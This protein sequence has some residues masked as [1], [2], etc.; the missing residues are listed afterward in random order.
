MCCNEGSR[1]PCPCSSINATWNVYGTFQMLRF[2]RTDVFPRLMW[3]KKSVGL[4]WGIFNAC[5]R[6]FPLLLSLS[7]DHVYFCSMVGG[8]CWK[9]LIRTVRDEKFYKKRQQVNDETDIV[10]YFAL[11][12]STLGFFVMMLV[13]MCTWFRDWFFGPARAKLVFDW[14]KSRN[15]CGSK[16]IWIWIRLDYA[17]AHE[18]S[19]LFYQLLYRQRRF[20]VWNPSV[21]S[22]TSYLCHCYWH[23]MS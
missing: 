13:A 9:Q 7:I 1:I 22:S 11:G 8:L 19:S 4:T 23:Y 18:Y 2:A 12:A 10:V 15:W 6:N 14:M 3:F 17:I 16:G 20:F 21:N 5:A